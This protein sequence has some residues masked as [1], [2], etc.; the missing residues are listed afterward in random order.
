MAFMKWFLKLL[1]ESVA[2]SAWGMIIYLSSYLWKMYKHLL[3]ISIS[4]HLLMTMSYYNPYLDGESLFQGGIWSKDCC[5]MFWRVCYCWSRSWCDYCI[6]GILARWLLRLMKDQSMSWYILRFTQ[7]GI[8]VIFFL[9]FWIL[10]IFSNFIT[11]L[12][13]C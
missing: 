4:I 13:I 8:W 9:I 7:Q 1:K 10:S 11:I 2:I 5:W 12:W 6:D 3:T